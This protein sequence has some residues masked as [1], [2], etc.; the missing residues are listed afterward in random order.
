MMLGII[1]G[2]FSSLISFIILDSIW[3]KIFVKDCYLNELR[4]LLNLS[5]GDKIQVN[6]LA[7]VLFYICIIFAIWYFAVYP[8]IS[9]SWYKSLIDGALIGLITYGTF[10]LTSHA[11]FKGW[12]WSITIPD[13]LWGMFLCGVVSLIGFLVAKW[14]S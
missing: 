14:I 10:D 9:K 11:L 3:I 4:H 2:I 13:I 8:N 5:G 12:S 7:A 1:I 6:I